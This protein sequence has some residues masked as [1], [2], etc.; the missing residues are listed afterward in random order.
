MV[1]SIVILPRS[2]LIIIAEFVIF[3]LDLIYFF[4][5]Y[6]IVSRLHYY[7]R[8]CSVVDQTFPVGRTSASLPTI[9]PIFPQIPL[10]RKKLT[11]R[12]PSDPPLLL[13]DKNI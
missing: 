9:L 12:V 2:Y 6:C 5:I 8:H 1:Q 4:R 7:S 11:G 13:S 3:D 10:N